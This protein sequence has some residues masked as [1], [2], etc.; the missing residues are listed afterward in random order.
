MLTYAQSVQKEISLFELHTECVKSSFELHVDCVR[1]LDN[2]EL[3]RKCVNKFNTEA[4]AL[5]RCH[6]A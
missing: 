6:T 1:N 2:S 4:F 5:L 3:R